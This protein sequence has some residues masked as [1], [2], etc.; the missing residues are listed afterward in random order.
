MKSF[1]HN[2]KRNVKSNKDFTKVK[3]KKSR[4][5]N[6]SRELDKETEKLHCIAL[7]TNFTI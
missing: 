3:D 6:V 7:R 2:L 5:L 4:L 1:G